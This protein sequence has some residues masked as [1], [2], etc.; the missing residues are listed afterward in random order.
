MIATL[1]CCIFF[2]IT[3]YHNAALVAAPPP[4]FSVLSFF[5]K[6]IYV[7]LACD[8]APGY[9]GF[10]DCRS[11]E[12][13]VYQKQTLVSMRAGNNVAPFFPAGL[14]LDGDYY[15]DDTLI[16]PS[17]N[18]GIRV[19]S[20]FC[21]NNT[22]RTASWDI[23][24]RILFNPNG[25]VYMYFGC[26]YQQEPL[27][28]CL[29]PTKYDDDTLYEVA[30]RDYSWH[31]Q[32]DP[33]QSKVITLFT[34]STV[35]S[36]YARH[37]LFKV[38]QPEIIIGEVNFTKTINIAMGPGGLSTLAMDV[39]PNP[40]APTNFVYSITAY[41][42]KVAAEHSY[43]G[44]WP[45]MPVA[46]EGKCEGIATVLNGARDGSGAKVQFNSGR[47]IVSSFGFLD[48]EKVE[49]TAEREGFC[50]CFVC[51]IAFS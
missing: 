36:V 30:I 34:V 45:D 14:A 19:N 43:L 4:L 50:L 39:T 25:Q 6:N 3:R 31:P 32:A 42:A 23:G 13:F 12:T 11:I 38:T 18:I 49:E 15:K 48:H 41:T 47:V 7:A 1:L 17:I 37:D 29:P 16:L 51:N 5:A 35:R 26:L 40:N 28:R 8:C 44:S 22:K 9:V 10:S 24:Y 33:A 46:P 20:V 27:C 2:I 21:G